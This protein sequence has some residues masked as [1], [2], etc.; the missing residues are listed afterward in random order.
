MRKSVQKARIKDD[1]Q[2]T[3][4]AQAMGKKL[5]C[6]SLEVVHYV[7]HEE[8]GQLFRVLGTWLP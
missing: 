2:E 8:L 3:G 5:G 6:K 1:T 7:Q 4:R